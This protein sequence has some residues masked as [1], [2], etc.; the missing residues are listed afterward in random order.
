MKLLFDDR[1]APL[2]SE[3]GF[4]E[5][6][7]SAA[8]DRFLEWQ[9]AIH[10]PLGRSFAKRTAAGPLSELLGLLPPLT[11]VHR[12][13]HLFVPTTG[14][15]T[16]YFDNGQQGTDAFST[17][18][19]L[20]QTIGCRGLRVLAVPDTIEVESRSARGRYGGLALEVYGP[21]E[22]DF[23]NY[24]RTISLIHDGDRWDFSQSGT[25]FPFEDVAAYS[26]RR[27]RDRFTFER[28]A[29]YLAELG[30]RPFREDFYRMTAAE[31]AWLIER[32]GRR[33]PGM[34]EFTLVEARAH[35]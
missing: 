23:L 21:E 14:A 2:T 9:R 22:T 13:R 26:A 7:A 27:T 16:A 3:I 10:E 29:R 28:L 20:A 35:Y 30:L 6:P 31:P 17:V 33:P 5:A 34:Q 12:L 8:A 18:S 15:W 25:P 32:H 1:L 19:Y 11:S 4:L 24:L